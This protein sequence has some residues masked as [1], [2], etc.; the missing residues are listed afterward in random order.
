MPQLSSA[1]TPSVCITRS[2]NFGSPLFTHY[3]RHRSN[4]KEFKECAKT[5]GFRSAGHILK[6]TTVDHVSQV[7][8]NK[9]QKH[10]QVIGQPDAIR[11]VC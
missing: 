2:W 11:G 1:V 4:K 10:L 8:E 6:N 9:L 3:A 7:A 5:A